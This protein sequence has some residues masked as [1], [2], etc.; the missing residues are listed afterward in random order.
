MNPEANTILETPRGGLYIYK[1]PPKMTVETPSGKTYHAK[2]VP[3][4]WVAIG[5]I[6]GIGSTVVA[7]SVAWGKISEAQ[8]AAAKSIEKQG[9]KIDSI[10]RDVSSTR[11]RV[12]SIE[13]QLSRGSH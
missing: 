1:E 4:S 13:G 6:L 2:V 9:D 8:V 10:Q 7:I 12:A 11:E 5:T 3:L